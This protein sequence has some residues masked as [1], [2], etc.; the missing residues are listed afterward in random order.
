MKLQNEQGQTTV[1]QRSLSR[2][3]FTEQR[4]KCGAVKKKKKKIISIC[5]SLYVFFLL[6]HF[7]QPKDPPL[8]Q[9]C[10]STA[11]AV[12]YPE[13]QTQRGKCQLIIIASFSRKCP[14]KP[15]PPMKMCYLSCNKKSHKNSFSGMQCVSLIVSL[16]FHSTGRAV[17]MSRGTTQRP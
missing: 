9:H 1:E 12:W 13:S 10:L 2:Q 3:Q 5:A 8:A 4:E 14:A 16:Q 15:D 17:S 11:Q 7:Y 6:A